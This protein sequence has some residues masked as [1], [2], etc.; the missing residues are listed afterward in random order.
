[1]AG[2]FEPDTFLDTA[3]EVAD[4]VFYGFNFNPSSGK[5]YV[6]I[7]DGDEPVSLPQTVVNIDRN[8]Y[9]AWFWSKNSVLF[10]WG[11]NGTRWQNK[12]LMRLV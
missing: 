6:D 7:L 11:T 10:Y 4:K 3:T 12:L 8:Q 5:L 2:T 9:Q 1:M